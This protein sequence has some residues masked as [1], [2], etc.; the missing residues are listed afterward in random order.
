LDDPG[1]GMG[2]L[3]APNQEIYAVFAEFGCG[4]KCICLWVM[5]KN[6]ETSEKISRGRGGIEKRELGR[7]PA[8]RSD[9]E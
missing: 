3:Y 2:R 9:S 4:V 8:G 5:I 1:A 6:V 7:A